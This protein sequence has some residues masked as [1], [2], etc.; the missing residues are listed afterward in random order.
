MNPAPST[1]CNAAHLVEKDRD[2]NRRD[3]DL[4]ERE[5][6]LTERE[7][8]IIRKEASQARFEEEAL[9]RAVWIEA[10]LW[11]D[12]ASEGEKSIQSRKGQGWQGWC[13]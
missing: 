7:K 5:R 3:A 2:L 10:V 13:V 12:C 6:A 9:Q 1:S 11:G 4:S 8:E